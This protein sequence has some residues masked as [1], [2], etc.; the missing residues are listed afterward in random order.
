MSFSVFN[1]Y[2]RKFGIDVNFF[3]DHSQIAWLT[4]LRSGISVTADTFGKIASY[5]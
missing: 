2:I 1:W 4:F 5:R 3:A